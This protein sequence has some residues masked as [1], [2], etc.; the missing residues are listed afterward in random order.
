MFVCER[1]REGERQRERG[2]KRYYQSNIQHSVSAFT[3]GKLKYGTQQ[4]ITL[5]NKKYKQK[6]KTPPPLP[7]QNQLGYASKTIIHKER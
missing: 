3:I 1:E 4:E 2:E 7:P 5:Q 6:Q